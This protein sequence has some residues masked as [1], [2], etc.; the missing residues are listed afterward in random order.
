VCT[1]VCTWSV[2]NAPGWSRTIF[3]C[4]QDR[5]STVELQGQRRLSVY[6]P[7]WSRTTTYG[8]LHRNST[9]KLSGQ[10]HL[11]VSAHSFTVSLLRRKSL[12]GLE[13]GISRFVSG[14]VVQL[15]HRDPYLSK[16]ESCFTSRLLLHPI[17]PCQD[18]NL[19]STL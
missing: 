4:L 17:Y 1:T 9:V 7:K 16:Y 3:N 2:I 15:R 8:L 10:K 12:P 11:S 5:R 18:S 19:E 6:A 14:C 13:P